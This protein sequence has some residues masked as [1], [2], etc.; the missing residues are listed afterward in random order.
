[1][2]TFTRDDA[3]MAFDLWESDIRFDITKYMTKE[4]ENAFPVASLTEQRVIYFFK[5][6]EKS[7]CKEA[8]PA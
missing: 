2:E 5:F 4:E 6:I 7:R 3:F 1:M 8:Q